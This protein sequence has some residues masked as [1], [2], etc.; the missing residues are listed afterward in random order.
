LKSEDERTRTSRF[1]KYMTTNE[2]EDNR[3]DVM[4]TPVFEVNHGCGCK[5]MIKIFYGR[6]NTTYAVSG[7]GKDFSLCYSRLY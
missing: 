5:F 2:K 6:N 3:M 7:K 4:N 1:K